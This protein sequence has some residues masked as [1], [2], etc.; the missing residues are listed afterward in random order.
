MTPTPI[1]P[2]LRLFDT[3]CHFD[4][5]AFS[6]DFPA[7]VAKAQ[8]QGVE[9]FLIPSIGPQNW[10]RVQQLAAEFP[11]VIY[12][13]LGYHPYFL[14]SA[15]ATLLPELEHALAQR[16]SSCVA[17]GEIGLDG[18]VA[19]EAR[20]QE[21]LLLGQLALAQSAQLPVILHSRK[22]HNRLL[23]LLKQSRF[24]FGGVLHAFSGSEQQALQFVELGFKIGVG[25]SITYPRAHKTRSTISALPL[26]HLVLETDAPDMPLCGYQ[27]QI[28]HPCRLPLVLNELALLRNS[29]KQSVASVIWKN[30]NSVFA[31]C[32]RMPNEM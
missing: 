18:M 21:R 22:T 12:Y 2:E 6:G 25:G 3:H 16:S 31:I 10:R 30:S 11:A 5:A 24:S 23:Q 28:N 14:S 1:K 32:E 4:F 29:D 17:V 19:V 13:A 7:E 15:A 8:R 27:G 20:L 9:R 26:E